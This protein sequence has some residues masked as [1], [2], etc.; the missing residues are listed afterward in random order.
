MDLN[1]PVEPE[2]SIA[3]NPVVAVAEDSIERPVHPPLAPGSAHDFTI[4]EGG[5]RK[6]TDLLVNGLGQMCTQRT[7][8]TTRPWRCTKRCGAV[9]FD[10]GNRR[11][12]VSKP[13]TC[14]PLQSAALKKK[15]NALGKK[16]AKEKKGK[17]KIVIQPILASLLAENPGADLPVLDNLIRNANR[18]VHK[19]RPPTFKTPDFVLD[20][21]H[22]SDP[23][24]VIGDIQV[25]N[26]ITRRH[27]VLATDQMLSYLANAKVWLVDG[28]F[29]LCGEPI[30]QLLSIHAHLQFDSNIIFAPLSFALMTHRTT[31]D[32]IVVLKQVKNSLPHEPKVEEVM[33]DFEPALWRAFRVVFPKIKM[34]GCGFHWAQAVNRKVG[35][36]GFAMGDF[37][38]DIC[39]T[40]RQLMTLNILPA[41]KIKPL[42]Q[43]IREQAAGPLLD[44]CDYMNKQWIESSIFQTECWSVYM[45]T[46]TTNNET[47]GWNHRMKLKADGKIGLNVYELIQLLFDEANLLPLNVELLCQDKLRN[48]QRRQHEDSQNRIFDLWRSYEN[49]NINT[50]ELLIYGAEVM[51]EVDSYRFNTNI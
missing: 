40:I 46:I 49:R 22:I 17:A 2:R 26:P 14:A 45:Q 47:E 30:E 36:V 31:K 29:E 35:Q 33:V 7:E 50:K 3:P 13:H 19:F 23:D 37:T 51:S 25:N 34:R 42:F 39:R 12:Y 48:Y 41:E 8:R 15:A 9:I 18:Y 21:Q 6:G 4:V 28:T 20:P 10:L 32:Y 44:L 5:S 24:F 16:A 43:E 38:P 11:F 1:T 27:L